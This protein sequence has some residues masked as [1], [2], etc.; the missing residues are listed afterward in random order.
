GINNNLFFPQ[1]HGREHLNISRWLTSLKKKSKEV[2]FAF[3]NNFFGISKTI[4]NESNP[5]FMAALDYD[6]NSSKQLGNDS[7]IQ[8][9][10]IFTEIFGYTSKSFIGPN[11]FWHDETEKILMKSN[12]EYLQGGYIQNLPN[13]K[14]RYH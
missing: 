11:Y 6:D 7:I 8:A 5:S 4:S 12:I 10:G 9:T 14:K 13:N 1:L 2:N 3:E